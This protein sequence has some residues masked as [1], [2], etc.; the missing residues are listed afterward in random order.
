MTVFDDPV[1]LAVFE[2]EP[3]N[4][5]IVI[6]AAR[7]SCPEFAQVASKFICV[8]VTVNATKIHDCLCDKHVT[9]RSFLW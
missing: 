6:M 1:W 5:Y 4:N 2:V 8:D 7:A 9:N 3:N